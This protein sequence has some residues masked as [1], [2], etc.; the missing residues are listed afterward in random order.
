MYVPLRAGAGPPLNAHSTAPAAAP[1]RPAAL[2]TAPR[3]GFVR[4]RSSQVTGTP[5]L[6]R[7]TH[8][9]W[10]RACA[11]SWLRSP[12][13]AAGRGPSGEPEWRGLRRSTGSVTSAEGNRIAS[14]LGGSVV[15]GEQ[16]V[17]PVSNCSHHWPLCYTARCTLYTEHCILHTIYRTL[18]TEH[19]I[20]H[21]ARCTLYT[22]HCI[23]HTVYF[24]LYTE[25]C[26]LNTVY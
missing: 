21:T 7:S 9:R 2:R 25:H 8:V 19:C 14:N 22:E 1:A 5:A 26:I 10:L 11:A 20:L 4:A 3:P 13:W 24:T 16:P 6:L 18:Y 15:A 12:I 23:L 17:P